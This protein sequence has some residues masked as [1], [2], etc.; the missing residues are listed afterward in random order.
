ME[1]YST[2]NHEKIEPGNVMETSSNFYTE[3]TCRRLLC[4]NKL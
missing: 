2:K 3:G 1:K 4:S